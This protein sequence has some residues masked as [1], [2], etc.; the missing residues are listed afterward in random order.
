MDILRTAGT[1]RCLSELRI[2][3]AAISSENC[4]SIREI[5]SLESGSDRRKTDLDRRTRD[6]YNCN[7]VACSQLVSELLDARLVAMPA[8]LMQL[9]FN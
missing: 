1:R 3:F 6:D 7:H 9:A 2:F 4:G 8:K 5:R